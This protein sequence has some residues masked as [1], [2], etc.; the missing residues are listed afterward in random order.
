ME[1]LPSSSSSSRSPST[2]AIKNPMEQLPSSSSTARSRATKSVNNPYNKRPKEGKS[3][4][5][6]TINSKKSK[7]L[8]NRDNDNVVSVS[9]PP[10]K[11][12]SKYECGNVVT[13]TSV[14]PSSNNKNNK[15]SHQSTN[16]DNIHVKKKLNFDGDNKSSKVTMTSS[17]TST[18]TSITS[19]SSCRTKVELYNINWLDNNQLKQE[20]KKY[21]LMTAAVPSIE[22]SI[23]LILNNST[24]A[25]IKAA[26]MLLIGLNGVTA[27]KFFLPLPTQRAKLVENF[28]VLIYNMKSMMVDNIKHEY[29]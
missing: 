19:S 12:N 5:E 16:I 29:R 22:K 26:F 11:S 23:T 15:S 8:L 3:N 9:T 20:G 25:K 28:L 4:D 6:S 2:K 17:N 27:S 18:D 10:S 7:S 21:D 14:I 13:N 24:A 1:R